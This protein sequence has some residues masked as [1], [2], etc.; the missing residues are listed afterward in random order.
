MCK[1]MSGN[2]TQWLK[3]PISPPYASAPTLSSP[4]P[5]VSLVLWKM[6]FSSRI[7]GDYTP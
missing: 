2:M 3:A 5:P 6:L 1:Y 7:H 4:H